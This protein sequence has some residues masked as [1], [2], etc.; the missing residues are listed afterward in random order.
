[1]LWQHYRLQQRYD[2]AA[3]TLEQLALTEYAYCFN[4]VLVAF[5]SLLTFCSL[6]C[7]MTLEKRTEYLTLAIGCAKSYQGPRVIQMMDM[8]RRL[9]IDL[10]T[11]NAQL[12][13]NFSESKNPIAMETEV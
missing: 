12:L 11:A 4:R 8:V 10:Q 5:D 2:V 3:E 13:H 7:D 1:M 6:R 9:E